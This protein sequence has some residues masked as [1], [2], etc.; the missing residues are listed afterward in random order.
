VS[1][2]AVGLTIENPRA[3]PEVFRLR[4]DY[5]RS[6]EMAGGLPLIFAP[7]RPEDAAELLDHVGGLVL[8]GGADIDPGLYGE[9]R[10]PELGPVFR[11]R[12]EFEI[13]LCR[14]ALRRD[15]P[16]LAIC[17]G[18]QVLNVATGG[19]LVQ[20][21]PSQ[22]AGA[23]AHDPDVERWET[24]HDVRI[25]PATRLREILGTENVAVNS[26]HH[27]AVKQLGEG[28]VVSAH[29][30]DGVVEGIEM[31]REARRFVVGVQWHPESF[32][33]HPPGFRP[34]FEALVGAANGSG[35]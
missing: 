18:H 23:G 26:F 31:P 3:E 33:D 7:G 11:Q 30:P 5:V 35:R 20:D 4:D 19:T 34:L 32:W 8:T 10:H 17:R 29:S 15:L 13:A 24:C 21:I 1:R 22:V 9:D 25:L 28:L 14:E 12:D 2:P 16:V 27:Q 6:V